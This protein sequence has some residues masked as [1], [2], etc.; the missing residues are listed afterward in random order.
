[1][2]AFGPGKGILCRFF[3][4][5][6]S[7]KKSMIKVD[8]G[9]DSG[10]RSEVNRTSTFFINGEKYLYDWEEGQLLNYLQMQIAGTLL[11]QG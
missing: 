11:G 4:H 8:K 10:I 3:E 9:F 5:Q 7:Y 2:N 6:Y 1:L